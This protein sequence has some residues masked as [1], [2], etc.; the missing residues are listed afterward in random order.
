MARGQ[1][2]GPDTIAA[3][4]ESDRESVKRTPSAMPIKSNDISPL[5]V[6][7]LGV[8]GKK[9]SQSKSMGPATAIW[10]SKIVDASS[11]LVWFGD[12]D[13]D[14]YREDLIKL[15]KQLGL[16]YILPESGE[17]LDDAMVM[18]DH[19]RIWVDDKFAKYAR[20][21]SVRLARISKNK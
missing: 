8:Q 3:D 15:S 19:E 11:T 6:E 12:M 17:S 20:L 4:L 2:L 10:N 9:I 18:I 7:I 14:R 5:A 21:K 16:L 13:I 1:D